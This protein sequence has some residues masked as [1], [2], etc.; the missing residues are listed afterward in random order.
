M[1]TWYTAHSSALVVSRDS[2]LQE[3]GESVLSLPD[4]ILLVIA[5]QVSGR[6]CLCLLLPLALT[7]EV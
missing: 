5:P 4:W 7:A 6:W 1:F 2:H 3:L